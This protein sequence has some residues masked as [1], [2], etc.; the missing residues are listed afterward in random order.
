MEIKSHW[1]RKHVTMADL[2]KDMKKSK[3]FKIA[4][5]DREDAQ[6]EVEETDPQAAVDLHDIDAL[7]P[8]IEDHIDGMLAMQ[9]NGAI[10]A[11]PPVIKFRKNWSL[12]VTDLS[13]QLWCE[14]QIELTL[15]TGRKRVTKE[16]EDGI[17]RHEQLEL[18]DHEVVE[19]QV[20]TNEDYLGIKLL[21]SINLIEQL[22]E[23]G[24]CR[25]IWLFGNFNGYV[26]RGIIDQL[27]LVP[28][29]G[30][31]PKRVLIS[32]TK[33]RKARRK[34][35]VQQMQGAALQVQAYCMMMENMRKGNESF[36]GLY[37]AFECDKEA[38]FTS[39]E[40]IAEVCLA[41]LE[42]RF[43]NAFKQLPEIATTMQLSYEHEGEV[44]DTSE[45]Q[46]HENSIMYTIN[47]LCNFWDGNREAEPVPVSYIE[48]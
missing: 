48:A 47:H 8:D 2:E 23:T 42:Q 31:G 1:Q 27:Q 40:L 25:E 11:L 44:F 43:K 34:P 26:V 7:I 38:P 17:E 24:K 36:E 33:T 28:P 29:G 35:S 30:R 45:I 3:T 37:R 5:K 21:N 10:T 6:D 4:K 18:E 15:I 13:S 19:V 20:E 46:L 39:P 9:E 14:K 41:N 22:M 16:M 12:S 32:D